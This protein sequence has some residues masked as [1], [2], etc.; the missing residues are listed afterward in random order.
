MR[1]NSESANW[2]V[3]YFVIRLI[4]IYVAIERI[5]CQ[6]FSFHTSSFWDFSNV[7]DVFAKNLSF[8]YH[9]VLFALVL[10]FYRVLWIWC[11]L[12]SKITVNRLKAELHNGPKQAK[13]KLHIFFS[14]SLSLRDNLIWNSFNLTP[15][16]LKNKQKI[17]RS[18]H[19]KF[20]FD[21]HD[22]S[23]NFEVWAQNWTFSLVWVLLLLF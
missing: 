21:I 12:I 9:W 4:M 16:G 5:T 23:F 11:R 1:P 8:T 17:N 3:L 15:K 14:C 2:T 7:N 10:E 18:S 6:S 19:F 22:L 20:D 13:A